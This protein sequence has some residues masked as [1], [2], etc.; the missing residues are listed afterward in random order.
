M[1]WLAGLAFLALRKLAI[2]LKNKRLWFLPYTFLVLAGCALAYAP[3]PFAWGSVASIA[4]KVVTWLLGW[5]AKLFSDPAVTVQIIA[6]VMLAL[7]LAFGLV[8]LLKDKKP[9]GWAKSM[10]YTVPVLA[11]VAAGPF[12]D[13]VV[14]AIQTIGGVG[15]TVLGKFR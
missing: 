3:L 15:P 10:V 13:T 7:A 11:L 2:K 9:D 4:A 8:D 6:G 14:L 1:L 12:A 5:P